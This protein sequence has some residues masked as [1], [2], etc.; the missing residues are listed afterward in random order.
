[1]GTWG[2]LLEVQCSMLVGK[3][4][5]SLHVWALQSFTAANGLF[6]TCQQD[7][8]HKKRKKHYAGHCS[9]FPLC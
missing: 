2:S 7:E 3:R 1:M 6:D 5:K 4:R 8:R 9:F